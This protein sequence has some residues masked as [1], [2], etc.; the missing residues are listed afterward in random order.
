MQSGL[1]LCFSHIPHCWKSHATAHVFCFRTA[2]FCYKDIVSNISLIK[3][4]NNSFAT[5]RLFSSLKRQQI[6]SLISSQ[7]SRISQGN[8]KRL[9]ECLGAQQDGTLVLS[10]DLHINTENEQVSIQV[11]DHGKYGRECSGRVLDSRPK[12]AGSSLTGITVLWSLSK[13][14]LS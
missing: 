11:N 2:W 9:V 3:T 5:G 12:A 13:T 10:P 4:L 7:A 6:T 1:S 14:H 8:V